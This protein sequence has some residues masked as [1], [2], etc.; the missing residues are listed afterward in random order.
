MITN[1]QT[2]GGVGRA[3]H[4][5]KALITFVTGG[6][7]T[8]ETTKALLPAMEQAGADLIEIGIPFSDPVAEGVIIQDANE[9][10]LKNGTTTDKIFDLVKEVR[11]EVTVPLVFL[12]YLNPI[13]TYG[14]EKFMQRCAQ[15]GVEGLIIPDL[16]FEEKA[17][18]SAICEAYGVELISLIAPTSHQRIKQI[19]KV[20][21]G[22]IYCV[23][24]MG[25]TGIRRQ[26]ETNLKEMLLSA[27]EVSN[28][29]CAVGFGIATPEQARDMARL[30]DG[31]IVGS[32]IVNI[33]AEQGESCVPDVCD[34]IRRMKA[35]VNQANKDLKET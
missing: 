3:F 27:K 15:C 11:T 19:A 4:H 18:L 10:A 9:R 25:V 30:S 31:A 34:Y 12:S 16:P 21:E 28:I 20:A 2:L 33:I 23:S 7:P 29:P 6:D 13:Y 24:S 8:L 32:A 1:N 35:G 17:E 22:F 26:I 5:Q 14:S